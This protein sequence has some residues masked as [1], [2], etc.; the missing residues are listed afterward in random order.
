MKTSH[1]MTAIAV[2]TLAFTST[3]YAQTHFDKTHPRRAEVNGR[4]A[5]QDKRIHNEVKEGDMS[6]RQAANLHRDDRS[7]RNQE[8]RMASHDGGH[9]TKA[10]QARLNHRENNVSKKIGQ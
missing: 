3:T 4:L 8:R 5:N 10:D 1:L 9:L 7:I 6:K 2:V